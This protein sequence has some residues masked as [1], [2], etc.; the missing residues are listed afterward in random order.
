VDAGVLAMKHQRTKEFLGCETYYVN[1]SMGESVYVNDRVYG[2][3][4]SRGWWD[5][6]LIV[7][8]WKYNSSA[9]GEMMKSWNETVLGNSGGNNSFVYS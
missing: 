8:D 3:S 1:G 4:R 2:I 9:F 5:G 7:D 6:G